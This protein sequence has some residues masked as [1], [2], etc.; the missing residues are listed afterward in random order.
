[1]SRR[2]TNF[3]HL[4][5]ANCVLA[6][7][8]NSRIER[9]RTGWYVVW[10]VGDQ[11][12]AK[13]WQCKGGQDFY[14]VWHKQWPGGGTASTALSQLVRW[15]RG[16]PVVPLA[17]WRYWAEESCRLLPAEAADWLLEAGYPEY[18]YCVLCTR[19]LTGAFDWWHRDGVSGPCC[20][21]TTGCKQQPAMGGE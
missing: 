7:F 20:G 17:T 19:Q 1:M 9:R 13:R 4:N 15:L 5:A 12:R 2:R 10:N 21:W 11:E 8:S 6:T 18:A 3:T 14:P 16:L